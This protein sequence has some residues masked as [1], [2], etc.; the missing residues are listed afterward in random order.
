IPYLALFVLPDFAGIMKMTSDVQGGR[1]VAEALARHFTQYQYTLNFL[2]PRLSTLPLSA[3]P[4][5]PLLDLK[6]P[7]L[8]VG[9]A[10]LLLQRT[11][12]VM[13]L[14]ALPLPLFVMLYSQGK[15]AGYF[16]PEFVLFL[17]GFWTLAISLFSAL[18]RRIRPRQE[19]IAVPMASLIL[20]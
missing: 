5:E 9:T 8:G 19:L 11:L 4:L 13:A 12:R 10:L 18:A 15:S 1:G 20:G 17:C 3:V 16:L 7:V 14:A 6:I 2:S